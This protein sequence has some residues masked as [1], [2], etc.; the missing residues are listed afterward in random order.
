MEKFPQS[1]YVPIMCLNPEEKLRNSWRT[2]WNKDTG[3]FLGK[4]VHYNVLHNDSRMMP[5]EGHYALQTQS[6]NLLGC[7]GEKAIFGE[8]TFRKSTKTKD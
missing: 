5:P 1:H 2:F 3:G 7:H 6:S 8:F 4:S